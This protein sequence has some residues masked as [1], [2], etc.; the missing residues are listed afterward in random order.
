MQIC[1]DE[2]QIILNE[3]GLPKGIRDSNGFLLF[4]PPVWKQPG[5]NK[6]YAGEVK[7]QSDLADTLLN[8]LKATQRQGGN[9]K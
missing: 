7:R 5:Q 1:D 6:R 9:M 3:Q 8:T 2:L 4:F